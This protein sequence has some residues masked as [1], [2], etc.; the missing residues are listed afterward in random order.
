MITAIATLYMKS[1]V[2]TIVEWEFDFQCN[3]IKNK[4][5]NRLDDHARLL[6]S[7]SALFDASD[8][9]TR[10]KWITFTQHQRV[11]KQLP[12]TQGFGFSLLVPHAELS[13]HI[14]KIRSEGFPKY[15]VR[16]EGDREIYVPVIY[17]YPFS[18]LNLSAF[19]FDTF[20][21]QVRR[22]AMELARDT[23]SAVLSGKV[24]LI[25][26]TD[27]KVQAGTVMYVPVYRKG[28]PTDSVEQRRAAIYGWVYNAYRM[29]D[30]MEGILG[31]RNMGK[32]GLH[33]KIFDGDF[34]SLQNMLYENIRTENGR[35]D[36]DVR[37]SRQIPLDFNGRHWTLCF[38]QTGGGFFAAEYT[39][40]W[41][42]LIGGALVSLLLFLLIRSV[43]NTSAKEHRMAGVLTVDLQASEE[44]HRLLTENIDDFFWLS[45]PSIDRIVY[46]SPAFQKIWGLSCESLYQQ[47]KL[48]MESIHPEDQDRVIA[49]LEKHFQKEWNIEYRI[50][51]TDGSMRW[52][53]DRGF[54]IRDKAGELIFMCGVAKDI[55]LRKLAEEMLKESENRFKEVLENSQDTSY[56]RN[57]QDNTYDYM[58]PV[59]TRISGYSPDEIKSLPVET[60]LNFMH[61]ED[62]PEIKRVIDESMSN[63]AEKSYQLEYR[64]RHKNGQYRWFQDRFTVMR[65]AGGLPLS[66]IGSVSDITEFKRLEEAKTKLEEQN[67]QFQKVES[68]SLMSGSIA[69]IFNNQLSVVMGYLGMAIRELP[70]RDSIALKLEKAM[71]A[72]IK[73]SEVS[74]SLLAYLGQKRVKLELLDLSELCRT[75]LPL[76]E[77]GKPGNVDMKTDFP[78]PGP[79][80]N[81]DVKQTQQILENIAINAWE[82]IGDGTG[83]IRLAVRMI[84][85][86][87]IPVSR[88]FP[89]EWRP[90]E[91]HYACL[92]V[93]DS[94]C[95][96]RKEDI[97][98]LFD[99]FFSTKFTG[100]GL[101]LSVVLGIVKNHDAGITVESRI[102]GGSV[103]RVFFPL[104]A[105]MAKE[106]SS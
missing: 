97:E 40:V 51:R 30:L 69:H 91:Q 20:S 92:E 29:N 7:E 68:L 57:L 82:A 80:I 75:S 12:G 15:T 32:K 77:V 31:S 39:K 58:S 64:F 60:V 22:T 62:L 78:S 50:I 43:L 5:L 61:P 94:G 41:F 14:Q 96:I 37:F 76:L 85:H 63:S 101:G 17:L 84:S 53:L 52:I 70:P 65:D 99:P 54:P 38:T 42:A 46:V 35:L 19:G 21:E 79:C 45:T 56:K 103:F 90:R 6:L 86:A 33:L 100:R 3:E 10:E 98:K 27:V 66:R 44:K 89:Y 16:P 105:Q 4:I 104:A 83:I 59:F 95:G 88:R 48:F 24:V 2:K 55:T 13:R 74:A 11:E 18:E 47:P 87:D 26:E 106:I 67:R 72:T 25:Q 9:V 81:A 93:A 8:V 1:S 28:M 102:G 23:D 49:T 36:S 71:Q 73:A 34:S